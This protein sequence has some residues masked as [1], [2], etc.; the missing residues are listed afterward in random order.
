MYE[1]IDNISRHSDWHPYSAASFPSGTSL[2]LI[3]VYAGLHCCLKVIA[4][5]VCVA[6]A[7][8]RP[9]GPHWS[10]RGPGREEN[11]ME[12]ENKGFFFFRISRC[13]GSGATGSISGT[14]WR[15]SG[16]WI[17]PLKAKGINAFHS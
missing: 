8:G 4:A 12:R 2:S 15:R 5:D 3:D 11:G 13:I 1:F 6:H 10:P 17:R 9:D 16:T 14:A 7:C